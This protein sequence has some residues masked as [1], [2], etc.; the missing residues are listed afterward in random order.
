LA[1]G[2]EGVDDEHASAAARARLGEH[3]RRRRID[4]DRLFGNR[5]GQTQEFARS[6]DRLGAVRAGEQAVVA[7]A[8]EALGSTRLRNR[9]MNSRTSSVIVV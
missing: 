9:R 6:R 3:L 8:M 4:L 1:A 2:I 5:S 7:D